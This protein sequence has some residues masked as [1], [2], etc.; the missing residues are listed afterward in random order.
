MPY[1]NVRDDQQIFVRD[2]GRQSTPENPP[3]IMLHGV[4]MQSAHWLPFVLPLARKHRFIVPDFRGFGH[5]HTVSHNRDCVVSNYADDVADIVEQLGLTQFKLVGI[6]MGAFVALQYQ[7][8][9]GDKSVDRYLHIDQSPRCINRKDWSWGLFGHDNQSRL[10]SAAN[11][12]SKLTPHIDNGTPYSALPKDLRLQ[13]WEDLGDF[14]S[15]A[16]SKPSHKMVAKK[17]C[18]NESIISRVMPVKNWPVYIRCLRAYIEQDYDMLATLQK[19]EKPISLLAGHK[20]KCC[21]S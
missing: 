13:L 17:L 14:F 4:G 7:G 16:L 1:I 9:Y 11:L 19:M 12:I 5:S 18:A 10:E 3:I 2:I 6:S 8:T 15:S 21:D 20:S